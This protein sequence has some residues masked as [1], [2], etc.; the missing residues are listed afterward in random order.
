M[1]N[2]RFLTMGA[3]VALSAC[4]AAAAVAQQPVKGEAVLAA[5]EKRLR[6]IAREE[7]ARAATGGGA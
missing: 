5:A 6:E 1:T 4:V 2:A 7:L 3:C